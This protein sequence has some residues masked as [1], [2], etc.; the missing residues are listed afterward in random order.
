MGIEDKKYLLETYGST[1][2]KASI[3]GYCIK[4]KTLKDKYN[5]YLFNFNDSEINEHER[6]RLE[7]IQLAGWYHYV[8]NDKT[9]YKKDG[10]QIEDRG[11]KIIV[12][13]GDY[14]KLAIA[15]VELALLKGWKLEDIK[16]GGEKEFVEE[17]NKEIAKR[18][19]QNATQNV[20]ENIIENDT[21]KDTQND[22]DSDGVKDNESGIGLQEQIEKMAAEWNGKSIDD[23]LAEL[24]AAERKP[25]R[26]LDV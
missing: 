18:Q 5:T 9:V 21:K 7:A 4:F 20:I 22:D 17:V 8:A 2:G 1:I 24:E 16:A 3:S 12:D 19:N 11:A 25:D 26:G 10:Q 15:A 6:K 13:G 23:T 14:E